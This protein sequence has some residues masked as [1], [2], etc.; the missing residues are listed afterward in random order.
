MLATYPETFDIMNKNHID[1]FH[2]TK[3]SALP[4]IMR[5]G[6]GSFDSLR[7]KG[8]TVLTGEE[9]SRKR[10]RPFISVTNDLDTAID[11]SSLSVSGQKVQ[12]FGIVIGMSSEDI[13]HL[14]HRSIK[15]DC[16]ELAVFDNIPIEYIK[17]LAVPEDKVEFVRKL[18]NNE[19]IAVTPMELDV[20]KRFYGWDDLDQLIISEEA[21][22]ERMND[23]KESKL[24]I[25]KD[26]MKEL[27][28]GRHKSG[29]LRM[30]NKIKNMIISRGK[31][32]GK[33]SRE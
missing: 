21:Y 26:D 9:Y 33:D 3:I 4:T 7:Q 1:L 17:M 30:Y 20:N 24:T 13:K 29:I 19:R 8:T 16:I 32:N 14:R 5:D 15:T 12:P 11:Y 2:G 31:D 28:E 22:I 6:L 25:G 27:A 10:G 18:I 23:K